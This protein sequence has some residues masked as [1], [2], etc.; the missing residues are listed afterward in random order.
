[1]ESMSNVQ[2]YILLGTV[3][4]GVIWQRVDATVL[5]AR[6]DRLGS[7]LGSRIDQVNTHLGSRI[8]Q[9]NSHLAGR[10][11]R[12]SDD[13]KQFYQTLGQHD[14]RLDNVEKK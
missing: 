1:M 8:D 3:L 4:A 9:V 14:A 12:I 11:D 13:L 6:I 10:I 5:N 7:E 2:F